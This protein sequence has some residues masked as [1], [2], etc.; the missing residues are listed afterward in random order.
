MDY[1]R[2]Y[3]ATQVK[4]VSTDLT[5]WW[6]VLLVSI[7]VDTRG[8]LVAA[9][10]VSILKVLA[11]QTAKTPLHYLTLASIFEIV[12]PS[13][14]WIPTFVALVMYSIELMYFKEGF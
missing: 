10:V 1:R 8:A 9:L 12:V 6:S 7:A 4:L 13:A 3:D 2:R 11:N 5:A 14:F